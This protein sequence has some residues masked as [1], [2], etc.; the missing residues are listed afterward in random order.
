VSLWL[1]ERVEAR[2]S[3]SSVILRRFAR[4]GRPRELARYSYDLSA[5]ENMRDWRPAVALAHSK[6]QSLG[7]RKMDLDIVLAGDFTRLAMLPWTAAVTERDAAAYALHQFRSIYGDTVDGWIVSLGI[8][9]PR[10]PRVA[11]AVERALIEVLR[12]EAAAHALRLRSVRPLLAALLDSR[13]AND[14]P[15]SGWV[16]L[17]EAGSVQVAC[18][19]DGNCIDVRSTR[20]TGDAATIL[21]ALLHESALSTD[22]DTEQAQLVLYASDAPDCSLLREHG[23]RVATATTEFA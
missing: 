20:S 21:L 23:W 7:W 17:A 5:G 2:L 18:F 16:A 22:R 15:A 9:R 13:S 6:I 4:G 8:A 10:C 14:V 19:V 12:T 11:A 3:P 1:R